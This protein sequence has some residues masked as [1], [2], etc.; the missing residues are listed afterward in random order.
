MI[1]TMTPNSRVFRYFFFLQT[2]RIFF[3]TNTIPIQSAYFV[4]I[5]ADGRY[6]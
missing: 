6:L 3:P 2:I 1:K 4:V 5:Y